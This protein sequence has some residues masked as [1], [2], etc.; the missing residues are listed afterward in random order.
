MSLRGVG[1]GQTGLSWLHPLS[2]NE[3][4]DTQAINMGF[5]FICLS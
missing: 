2:G 5:S 4:R 1:A 3:V